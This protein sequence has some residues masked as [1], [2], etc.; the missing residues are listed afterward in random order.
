MECKTFGGCSPE[1]P[2]EYL[3]YRFMESYRKYYNTSDLLAPDEI[4]QISELHKHNKL[5]VIIYHSTK[6]LVCNYKVPG[7]GS[8]IICITGN[9][10]SSLAKW[11]MN[12][13]KFA[14]SPSI[15]SGDIFNRTPK[16]LAFWL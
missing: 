9:P 5:Y 4:L 14:S 16:N 13:I 7:K 1:V 2:S 10:S 12:T 8:N 6:F 15:K 3:C 11:L